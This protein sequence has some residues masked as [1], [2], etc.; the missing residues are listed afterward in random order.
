MAGRAPRSILNKQFQ[1]QN[2]VL[3]PFVSVHERVPLVGA[4][5]NVVGLFWPPAMSDSMTLSSSWCSSISVS[6]SRT[7]CGG[8]GVT[9]SKKHQWIWKA[10]S[11]G[12]MVTYSVKHESPPTNHI[13]ITYMYV[14]VGHELGVLQHWATAQ[15][16]SCMNDNYTTS[17]AIKPHPPPQTMRCSWWARWSWAVSRGSCRPCWGSYDCPSTHLLGMLLWPHRTFSV[18]V[19]GGGVSNYYPR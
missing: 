9:T 18:C 19:W 16:Q 13:I 3:N 4:P 1:G 17:R 15:L 2:L 6:S 10:T 11:K 8:G 5:G 7:L 14:D 12:S